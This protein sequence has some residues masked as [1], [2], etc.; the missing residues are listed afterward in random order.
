MSSLMGAEYFQSKTGVHYCTILILGL[1]LYQLGYLEEESL[2]N[3]VGAQCIF[4]P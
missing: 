1:S 3:N 2:V 4:M